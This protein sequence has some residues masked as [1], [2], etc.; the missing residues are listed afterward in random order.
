[1]F[2]VTYE[3]PTLKSLGHFPLPP[4]RFW[5]FLAV[6]AL[7]DNAG[8]PPPNSSAL[9]LDV[10]EIS[11]TYEPRMGNN[12]GADY[13]ARFTTGL[14]LFTE[15]PEDLRNLAGHFRGDPPPF[16]SSKGPS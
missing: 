3:G 12:A 6:A 16:N 10:G 1:M 2:T 7:S 15:L 13:I 8:R 9:L 5:V 11:E 4:R 14:S